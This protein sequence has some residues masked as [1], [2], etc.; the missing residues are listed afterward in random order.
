MYLLYVVAHF[1]FFFFFFFF[2]YSGSVSGDFLP[3]GHYRLIDNAKRTDKPKWTME[4]FVHSYTSLWMCKQNNLIGLNSVWVGHCLPVFTVSS[5]DWR[6]NMSELL[7][8]CCSPF[9]LLLTRSLFF[10]FFF[11]FTLLFS[12]LFNSHVL[13]IAVCSVLLLFFLPL[14]VS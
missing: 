6:S 2:P 3:S 1:L 4:H 5:F 11:L 12:V 13:V 8:D 14:C 9:F 10:F 7:M